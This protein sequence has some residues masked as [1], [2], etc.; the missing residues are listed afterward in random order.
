VKAA[1]YTLMAGILA[2][3]LVGVAA[4]VFVRIIIAADQSDEAQRTCRAGGAR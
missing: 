2:T 1:F 4:T 3:L